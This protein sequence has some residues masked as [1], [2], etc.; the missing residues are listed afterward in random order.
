MR[1]LP[2]FLFV[3][4][5]SFGQNTATKYQKH[6][7]IFYYLEKAYGSSEEFLYLKRAI[8]LSEEI[9]HDSLTR[10]S[11]IAYASA[12]YFRGNSLEKAKSIDELKGFYRSEKDSFALAKILHIKAMSFK[13]QLKLDSSFY[14][15][16][17]S[18]DI[19]MRIKDSIEV[20]RRLLSMGLM[21][22]NENDLVGAESSLIEGLGYLEPI[23]NEYRF[24][25]NTYNNLGL[26]LVNMGRFQESR[27]YFVQAFKTQEGN[28]NL[29]SKQKGILDYYNNMGFSF[30]K[31][32]KYK[33]ALDTLN[34]GLKFKTDQNFSSAREAII[35]NIADCYYELGDK[36]E[37]LKGFLRL[38]KLRTDRNDIYGQ[39][40]SHN[41]LSQYYMEQNNFEKA[42]YHAEFG[43]QLAK[44]VKNNYTILSA[45]S[46][47]IKLSSNKQAKEYFK[48]YETLNEILIN[49]ERN[50]KDQF[51]KVRYETVKKEKRNKEL[52]LESE[53][54]R[55]QKIIG[56]LF[57][58]A[59]LL[60]LG[61]S[62]TA[63][64]ARR[65]KLMYE[66]QLEKATAREEE[67]QQ[68]AKSL[69]D[70]VAGDLRMLHQ[71]LSKTELQGEAKSVEKIKDNV[72][73]LSHQLSSVSFDEVS[74]K[75]QLINLISDNFSLNFRIKVEG[76]DSIPWEEV[77]NTIKRTLY[78]SIR[79]SLQNTLK[80]AN[81]DQFFIRFSGEKKE[82]LLL[83]EDNGKGFQKGKGKKGIGLKNLKERVEEIQGTFEINSSEQGT[84]TT[85]TI[86]I[87]GR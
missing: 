56:W 60:G 43:H 66:A 15:Y 65:K 26:V 85:I 81:A 39:S 61:F 22:I 55:Q 16:Y 24:T 13:R 78:L 62:F 11:K 54:Q 5:F 2:I 57:S 38:L 30:L 59:A 29:D 40:L 35:G 76:M 17:Q 69:H 1:L 19:S 31:E 53:R 82:I 50:I 36:K 20:G 71:K 58:L 27:N 42:L 44:K 51:A 74:F 21:Q 46:K 84:Q 41:G 72:R 7:S 28:A 14:Y 37:A 8:L 49:R 63:F 68:I 75:D 32:R 33:Q 3:S 83:L 48:E 87:N 12:G 4:F 73:N 10:V 77:N 25:A 70:E 45:L 64:R 86:P 6:D 79:E 47:L 80:H 18:K 67:R 34:K 23:E 9:E 52:I